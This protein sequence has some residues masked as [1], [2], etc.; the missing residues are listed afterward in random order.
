VQRVPGGPVLLGR[1]PAR[2]LG[3]SQGVLQCF[4]GAQVAKCMQTGCICM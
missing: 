2:C 4:A 3:C 1:L